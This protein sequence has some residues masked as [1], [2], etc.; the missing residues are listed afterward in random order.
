MNDDDDSPR[1][2]WRLPLPLGLLFFAC[3]L[4]LLCALYWL[5]FVGL[6]I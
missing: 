2:P 3:S 5:G 1:L 4:L 6:Y